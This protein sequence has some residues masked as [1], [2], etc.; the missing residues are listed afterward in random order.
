L[1]QPEDGETSVQTDGAQSV[2]VTADGR[3]L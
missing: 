1:L 3:G 2:Y